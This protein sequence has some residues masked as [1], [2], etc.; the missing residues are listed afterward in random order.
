[1][2]YEKRLTENLETWFLVLALSVMSS[3]TLDLQC[4]PAGEPVFSFQL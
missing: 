2:Y 1:M 3:V 4:K